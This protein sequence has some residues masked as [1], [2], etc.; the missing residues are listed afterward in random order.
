M[1]KEKFLKKLAKETNKLPLEEGEDLLSYYREYIDEAEDQETLLNQLP[2]PKE[3]IKSIKRDI[4]DGNGGEKGFDLGTHTLTITTKQKIN[5]GQ[6][7]SAK[8]Q[9]CFLALYA[10]ICAALF[11]FCYALYPTAFM[12][13]TT[14]AAL[15]PSIFLPVV[16]FIACML[17]HSFV[18]K[19]QWVIP[20]ESG[21]SRY[22]VLRLLLP[23]FVIV[24]FIASLKLCYKL[25][26]IITF[27]DNLPTY[28]VMERFI[29]SQI[30]NYAELR[31]PF[32]FY[33]SLAFF[34]LLPINF[35]VNK[36]KDDWESHWHKMVTVLSLLLL[37]SSGGV[38]S[39]FLGT[40]ATMEESRVQYIASLGN[41][42]SS[43]ER[44][45]YFRNNY[46]LL[47]ILQ[48]LDVIAWDL[49][50]VNISQTY[51]WKDIC[52]ITLYTN[53]PEQENTQ[54]Y[55]QY[56]AKKL[57]IPEDHVTIHWERPPEEFPEDWS[58][59]GEAS[60]QYLDGYFNT[61]S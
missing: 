53:F 27:L 44:E 28:T 15:A 42:S 17:L 58:P 21:F 10:I 37:L 50:D 47:D 4:K 11:D 54:Y 22:F 38:L 34:S 35:V 30:Y 46:D 7:T 20:L 51:V 39:L 6:I 61:T 24:V 26:F 25:G 3:I 56:F 9:M 23:Q 19:K 40:S 16:L 60:N 57:Q 2:P 29:A 8:K 32:F 43:E 18:M 14:G 48:K 31:L 33:F 36:W 59:S 12:D 52:E 55:T 5:N 49:T 41:F 13:V 1:N 45:A